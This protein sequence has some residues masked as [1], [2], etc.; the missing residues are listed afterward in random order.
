MTNHLTAVETDSKTHTRF[1][2]ILTLTEV[3]LGSLLHSFKIPLSGQCLSLNQGFLLSRATLKTKN[4]KT[5]LVIS[6]VAALLKSLS[7]AGKKLTPM[8]AISAQ[9]TLFGLSTLIFGVNFLG[10]FLGM[11]FLSL[12]AYLQPLLLYLLLYGKTLVDVGQYFL[13]QIEALTPITSSLLLEVIIAMILLKCVIATFLLFLAYKLSDEKLNYYFEFLKKIKSKP[14][15]SNQNTSTPTLKENI[16]NSF[17]DLFN[18]LFI[19]SLILTALFF[20]ITQQKTIFIFINLLRP[21]AIGFVLFFLIRIT[22]SNRFIQKLQNT[23]FKSLA[24]QV[25]ETLKLIKGTK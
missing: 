20:F 7:P 16:L 25:S 17:K 19:V 24:T 3:G 2:A 5:P 15:F 13:K 4:R 11:I 22:P 1:T 21:I 23:R 8:L 6:N 14:K 18:P 10:L 9:G 12:W